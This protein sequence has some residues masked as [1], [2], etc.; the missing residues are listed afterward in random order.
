MEFCDFFTHCH[1]SFDPFENY[2]SIERCCHKIHY[3]IKTYTLDEFEKI[4]NIID[5][6]NSYVNIWGDRP[7]ERDADKRYCFVSKCFYEG[8]LEHFNTFEIALDM[9]C[10]ARC[11]WCGF[12]NQI[13]EVKRQKLNLRLKNIYYKTIENIVEQADYDCELRL[14]DHGEPLLWKK[15]FL[16]FTQKLSQNKHI[17]KVLFTTNGL[18]LLDEDI[19]KVLFDFKDL[20][21]IVCSINAFSDERR[22][23]TMGIKHVNEIIEKANMLSDAV[24]SYVISENEDVEE[25]KKL[26]KDF[27]KKTL[28]KLYIWSNARDSS[29]ES[30]LEKVK[31]FVDFTDSHPFL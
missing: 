5:E 23:P 1:I 21:G 24:F 16:N 18:G 11:K 7:G 9:S 29:T 26:Y 20:F 14:T 28:R 3:P 17:K 6:L 13:E 4:D 15:E 19:Y 10:N 27:R 25:F 12:G 8:K 22:F 2:V 31:E 30:L